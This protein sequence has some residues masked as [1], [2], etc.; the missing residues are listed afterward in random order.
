VSIVHQQR[1]RIG[2]IRCAKHEVHV[3]VPEHRQL[4][5]HTDAVNVRL[6][7]FYLFVHHIP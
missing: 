1:I 7:R 2:R 6:P 5:R 3:V 4:G